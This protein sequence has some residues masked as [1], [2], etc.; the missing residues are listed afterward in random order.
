MWIVLGIVLLGVA[1]ILLVYAGKEKDVLSGLTGIA[2]MIVDIFLLMVTMSGVI[3][4]ISGPSGIYTDAI[5]RLV[6]QVEVHNKK[7]RILVV[8][9]RK[10]PTTLYCVYNKQGVVLPKDTSFVERVG[11]EA[12]PV[13][14][15][16]LN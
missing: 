15:P 5:Y 12:K 2:L 7:S 10:D 3:G 1:V 13:N 6:A 14:L 9:D 11:D 16:G 4:D 8:Q